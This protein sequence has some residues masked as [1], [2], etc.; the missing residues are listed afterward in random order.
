[1]ICLFSHYFDKNYIPNY[2]LY[3]LEKL[4]NVVDELILL[5]NER[6]I[7][8]VHIVESMGISVNM[9]ENSGY[10]F[11]MYYKYLMD[12]HIDCDKL[13]L[14]NDSMILFNNL[15]NVISW[16]NSHK[17]YNFLGLT[18]SIEISYHLQSYF[19]VLDRE[20]QKEFLQYLMEHGIK[21]EFREVV[22]VYEVGFSKRMLENYKIKSML[23]NRLYTEI[24]KTNSVVYFPNRL[25]K[26][27]LP[28]IKKKVIFN[29]FTDEERNFLKSINYSFNN[30]YWEYLSD[31]KEESL[32][33]NYIKEL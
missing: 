25:I 9:Y 5:T 3:Y 21:N 33:I 16:V 19:L 15:D 17:D 1:M 18:G 4:N 20:V 27:G 24:S 26:N 31:F 30:N 12:N 11:G 14:A 32:N 10:D 29:T 23:P 13:I 7:S 6:E 2:V 8:N 22:N 28:M